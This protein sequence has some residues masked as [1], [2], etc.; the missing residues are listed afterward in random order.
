MTAG[1]AS[2]NV[3]YESKNVP[4]SFKK[5]IRQAKKNWF[6]NIIKTNIINFVSDICDLIFLDIFFWL[7]LRKD[8]SIIFSVFKRGVDSKVQSKS[9]LPSSTEY[10]EKLVRYSVIITGLYKVLYWG[11]DFKTL[12]EAFW[13]KS[14][15]RKDKREK[16]R[17]R[18]NGRF[19]DN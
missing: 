18:R 5:F 2:T 6:V 13:G 17:K 14:K 16:E 9:E 8:C 10:P 4:E 19:K 15:K 7:F 3:K 12:W 11:Y 1:E